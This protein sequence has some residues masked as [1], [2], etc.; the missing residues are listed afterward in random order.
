MEKWI[1]LFFVTCIF[2][3]D[4]FPER[5][6]EFKHQ[7]ISNMLAWSLIQFLKMPFFVSAA[8]CQLVRCC[9]GI[10]P[11][12]SWDGPVASFHKDHVPRLDLNR[13]S[14]V[15]AGYLWM[16]SCILKCGPYSIT[17]VHY[18]VILEPVFFSI[19]AKYQT[20]GLKMS[21]KPFFRHWA[22]PIWARWC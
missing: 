15:K 19:L 9:R 17:Q 12:A 16:A 21:V 5:R 8:R 1:R 4:Y 18:F 13:K 14:R 22:W 6:I 3:W 7:I 10:S 2:V 20:K 11:T